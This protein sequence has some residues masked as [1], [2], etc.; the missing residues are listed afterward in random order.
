LLPL[1]EFPA[2]MISPPDC[3]VTAKHM[4]MAGLGRKRIGATV[5][6]HY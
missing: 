4:G 1:P 5:H 6:R 3:A 2:D